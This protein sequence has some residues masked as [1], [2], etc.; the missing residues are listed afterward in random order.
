MRVLSSVPL[1]GPWNYGQWKIAI[2][3]PSRPKMPV[4]TREENR[5]LKPPTSAQ[6]CSSGDLSSAIIS[7]FDCLKFTRLSGISIL[8]FND[9]KLVHHFVI[10]LARFVD[11]ASLRHLPPCECQPKQRRNKILHIY[12]FPSSGN[13]IQFTL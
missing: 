12:K 8:I 13:R 2:S 11:T 9:A 3:G 1:N 6:F 4:D 10:L 7:I 5:S